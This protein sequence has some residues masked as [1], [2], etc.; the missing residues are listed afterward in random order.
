ME[1]RRFLNRLLGLPLK[2]QN[3]L[4]DIF[5]ATL[6]AV[7]GAARKDGKYDEGIADLSGAA[8][9]MEAPESSLWTD[10]LT[11]A[12]MR[13][14]VV[15]VDRGVSWH[16]ACEK[17]DARLQADAREKAKATAAAAR[18]GG[19]H[20]GGGTAPSAEGAAPRRPRRLADE[21]DEEGEEDE[22]DEGGEGGEGGAMSKNED[23]MEDF[24]VD[25]D[26]E[27]EEAEEEEEAAAEE[28]DEV[29]EQQEARVGAGAETAAG[30]G[31]EGEG[32]G[33]EVELEDVSDDEEVALPD[34]SPAADTSKPPPR[35]PRPPRGAAHFTG[36]HRSRFLQAG[37]RLYVLA[38]PR[39]NRE[40]LYLL[41]RPNTGD[42][43]FE[44]E[45]CDLR[46]KYEKITP[47][48]AKVG[49]S[50]AYEGA[51]HEGVGGRLSRL[52]MLTGCTL[53]LLPLLDG[54]V[55]RHAAALTKRDQAVAAMRVQLE[56][57]RLVG[58]RFPRVLMGRQRAATA[59]PRQQRAAPPT[60]AAACLPC[61]H[62]TWTRPSHACAACCLPS[63]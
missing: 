28:E 12:E 50:A 57:R 44:E 5:C 32:E 56:E 6:E 54:L 61:R 60:T 39:A 36:F 14:A 19:A 55:K 59:K 29:H 23:D 63:R 24:I 4:F 26:D 62:C 1:V 22:E 47:E 15:S 53:P 41:T 20:G 30:G 16:A 21:E 25:D 40:G 38:V 13:S 9:S 34:G 10:P 31:D 8:V 33:E 43:P 27:E 51:R 2:E 17:L 3:L 45:E 46:R 42:S 35:P 52:Q 58:V 11:G 37:E 49:W 18:S 48:A 7:I